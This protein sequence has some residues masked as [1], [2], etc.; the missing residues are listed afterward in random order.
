MINSKKHHKSEIEE[1]RSHRNKLRA[2]NSFL[3]KS[4][5]DLLNSFNV[6]N[7]VALV[8]FDSLKELN[9]NQIYDVNESVS[10]MLEEKTENK[11]V[12]TTYM[13]ENGRFS[14][15]EHDCFEVVEVVK[16]NLFETERGYKVYTQGEIVTYSPFEKHKPYATSNSVYKVIFY[17]KLP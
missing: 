9:L 6:D 2:E 5:E 13:Q 11:L 17:K 7:G 10:F 8:S 1:L 15:Q 4:T 14:L 3:I 12:F 16:G